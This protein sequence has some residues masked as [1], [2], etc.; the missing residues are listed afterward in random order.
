MLLQTVFYLCPHLKKKMPMAAMEKS[1]SPCPGALQFAVI[2][3]CLVWSDGCHIIPTDT[4]F[5]DTS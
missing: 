5:S 1:I 3:L 4:E 2:A